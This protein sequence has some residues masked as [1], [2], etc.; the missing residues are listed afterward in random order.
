M[1]VKFQPS[2]M[3]QLRNHFPTP[4]IAVDITGSLFDIL[5]TVSLS[6]LKPFCGVPPLTTNPTTWRLCAA[7]KVREGGCTN[8]GLITRNFLQSWKN[9]WEVSKYEKSFFYSSPRVLIT[10]KIRI[11]YKPHIPQRTKFLRL[12]L[13]SILHSA[14]NCWPFQLGLIK[15]KLLFTFSYDEIMHI[16]I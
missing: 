16:P 13:V 9:L 3:A 4:W 6:D 7:S 11:L 2:H 8:S 1:F 14:R 5:G 12:E 15:T 10:L